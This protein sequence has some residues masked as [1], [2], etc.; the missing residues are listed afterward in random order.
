MPVCLPTALCG[1]GAKKLLSHSR[2]WRTEHLPS[3]RSL[4]EPAE[5]RVFFARRT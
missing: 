4:K 1:N 3:L 2:P 5:W